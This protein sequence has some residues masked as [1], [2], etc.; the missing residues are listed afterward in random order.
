MKCTALLVILI[1]ACTALDVQAKDSLSA[2]GTGTGAMF[3]DYNFP[4][5]PGAQHLCHQNVL[6]SAGSSG[7]RIEIAWDA[8]AL[9][10]SPTEVV[11]FYREHLG[12]SGFVAKGQGGTWTVPAGA[13]HP[14]SILEVSSV[15]SDGPQRACKQ[16]P[17]GTQTILLLSSMRQ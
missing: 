4:V 3:A 5:V 15:D 16:A 7:A 14:R 17:S 8:F 9:A 13:T 1:A 6:G 11:A 12:A 10:S 2:E